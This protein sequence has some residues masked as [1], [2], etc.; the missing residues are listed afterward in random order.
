MS[1]SCCGACGGQDSQAQK[2]K[3]AVQEQAPVPDTKKEQK[4]EE[5]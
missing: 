3:A 1:D 5:K 4:K 2:D